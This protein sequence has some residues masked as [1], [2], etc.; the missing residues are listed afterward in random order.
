[1]TRSGSTAGELHLGVVGFGRLVRHY[2]LPAL[3]ALAGIHVVA[4][5]D[6]LPESRQSARQRL[7]DA[8][9]YADNGRML[10]QVRLDGVL[11]A[12]RPRHT[13]RSGPLRPLAAFRHSSKSHSRCHLSF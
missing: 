4:V 5:V 3:R 8:E 12:L 2:Y 9:I 13:S 10:D 7:P 6:P 1:M 11:V